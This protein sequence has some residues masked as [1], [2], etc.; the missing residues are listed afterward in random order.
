MR[1]AF[2]LALSTSFFFVVLPSILKSD[3]LFYPRLLARA[4]IYKL[5]K[6]AFYLLFKETFLPFLVLFYFDFSLFSWSYMV[7]V[8]VFEF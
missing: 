2:S 5:R 8:K 4:A 1:A 6:W 7:L 3:R